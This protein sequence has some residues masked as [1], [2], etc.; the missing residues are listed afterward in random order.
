MVV[1]T[2]S[3]MIETKEYQMCEDGS[4]PFGSTQQYTLQVVA[5]PARNT[6][7]NSIGVNAEIHIA[8]SFTNV[9]TVMAEATV[10]TTVSRKAGKKGKM[11]EANKPVRSEMI[12]K[13]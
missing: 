12:K 2:L 1:H 11:V 6:A 8:N 5:I 4:R 13:I 7:G 10:Y 3:H 9:P